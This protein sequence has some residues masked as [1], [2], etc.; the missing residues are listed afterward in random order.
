MQFFQK[1]NSA[2]RK[3][4]LALLVLYGLLVLYSIMTIAVGNI[5]PQAM[6]PIITL[7]GFSFAVLH[8]SDRLGWKKAL[9]LLGLVFVV[10][11]LF[12]S[13]GVATGLVYG[14]YHYT[15]LLGPKFLGLVPYLIAVS[16]FMMMYPSFVITEWLI[17]SAWTG[18]KRILS[19]AAISG[20][21]MTSWD[22][23]MDP[24]M[25]AGKHWVWEVHGDFFGVPLQNYW[26]WWLT[27]FT[28]FVIY[29]LVTRN[30]PS[31]KEAWFD[32]LAL[33]AFMITGFGNVILALTG[34]GGGPGL[35][36]FFALAP[37]VIM[38]WISMGK[39]GTAVI[40]RV[41]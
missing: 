30:R 4:M 14:P 19:I 41:N 25:V 27:V 12:E 38:A 39:D 3:L 26:G 40:E 36:G 24:I 34:G 28:T 23:V 15:E 9:L 32:R 1:G 7:T 5:P 6:T 10:A 33:I 31:V 8:A 2:R 13:I 18:A 22:V 29:L 37:W 21:V 16:W 17:P 20:L 35:A 11:L